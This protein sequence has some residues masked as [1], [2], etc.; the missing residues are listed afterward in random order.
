MQC[1]QMG[2][3]VVNGSVHTARK[4]HQRKNILMC[5]VWRVLCELG[6]S[7]TAVL[8]IVVVIVIVVL[9]VLDSTRS[10]PLPPQLPRI[11][12]LGAHLSSHVSH[13]LIT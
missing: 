11:L 4:L 10:P 7:H 8:V 12:P 2:P 3:V 6:L 1:K 5:I 13:A 9:I